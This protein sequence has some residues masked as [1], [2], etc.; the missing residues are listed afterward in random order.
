[1]DCGGKGTY[2]EK[3]GFEGRLFY[4]GKRGSIPLVL[5]QFV[6]DV[7]LG[8]WKRQYQGWVVIGYTG[9][10]HFQAFQ[11]KEAIAFECEFAESFVYEILESGSGKWACLGAMADE[12]DVVIGGGASSY[13]E[14]EIGFAAN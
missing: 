7:D 12:V 13:T 14:V 2:K 8:P 6:V 4:R 3:A 1:M 11:R 10:V 9:D 5:N